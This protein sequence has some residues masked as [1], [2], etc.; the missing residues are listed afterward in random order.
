MLNKDNKTQKI[1]LSKIFEG[2]IST[3]AAV[4]LI[5]HEIKIDI[6]KIILDF[7]NIDFISRSFTH[8]L[9]RFIENHERK[10]EIANTKKSVKDML[11]LVKSAKVKTKQEISNSTII[12]LSSHTA[13]F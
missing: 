11:A 6:D 9:L 10:V 13:S 12:K 1:K 3:R 8:E 7:A 2:N 5:N 4:A